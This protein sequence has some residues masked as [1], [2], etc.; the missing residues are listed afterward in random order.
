M[1]L[2]GSQVS[3]ALALIQ[4]SQGTGRLKPLLRSTK[5]DDDILSVKESLGINSHNLRF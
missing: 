2:L 3:V 1:W 4:L 5:S